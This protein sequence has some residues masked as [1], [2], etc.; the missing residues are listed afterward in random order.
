MAWGWERGPQVWPGALPGFS[1]PCSKSVMVAPAADGRPHGTRRCALCWP[2]PVPWAESC[3]W[4][5]LGA[6]KGSAQRRQPWC[7]RLLTRLLVPAALREHSE[8]PRERELLTVAGAVLSSA[9]H[10]PQS[11][12]CLKRGGKMTWDPSAASLLPWGHQR[13][14]FSHGRYTNMASLLGPRRKVTCRSPAPSRD[15][16][17]VTLRQA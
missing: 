3:F 6:P 12:C 13:L 15:R 16:E 2:G 11:V 8:W 4:E 9:L 14:T 10:P 17:Q 1:G 5:F 7:G